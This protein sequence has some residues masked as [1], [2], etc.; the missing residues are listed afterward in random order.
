MRFS[1]CDL[2]D[3]GVPVRPFDV[4]L[5]A[6]AADTTLGELLAAA[7]LAGLRSGDSVDLDG[8]PVEEA[9]PIVH[10]GLA[11]GSV[12]TLRHGPHRA[13]TGTRPLVE[14]TQIAGPDSGTVVG[15]DPA[16]TPSATVAAGSSE[17]PYATRACGS[18][19][20]T[21]ATVP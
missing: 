7:G 16:S 5:A 17:A 10:L 21:T 4:T 14:L 13:G 18:T 12:L 8:V 1:I 6:Y 11:S 19:S 2:R 15:L 20:A 9:L 3:P